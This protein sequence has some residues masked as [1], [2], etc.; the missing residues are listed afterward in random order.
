MNKLYTGDNLEIMREMPDASVD[1]IATDPPF[2]TGRD[3]GQFDDR[4]EGGLKGYLKFMEERA[5]EMH[6]LLK[7]TGSLY[8][9]CDPTASHYLKVMLDGV[10]GIDNFRNEIVWCYDKARPASRMYRR[11]HDAILFYTKG[12]SYPFHLPIIPNKSATTK[13]FIGGP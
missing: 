6:R 11:N 5:V 3:W 1:L 9:H 12:D 2:N 4:W 13:I 10:F 7:P 8:L